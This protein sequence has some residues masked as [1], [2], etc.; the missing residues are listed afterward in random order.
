M[1]KFLRGP[2]S[3]HAAV[4]RGCYL[5]CLQAP[6]LRL[7]SRNWVVE[8]PSPEIAVRVNQPLT[9]ALSRGTVLTASAAHQ[10]DM[11]AKEPLLEDG[12]Q[13]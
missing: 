12:A 13:V 3:C 9:I 11:I 10:V 4:A 6:F 1:S 5:S 7:A 2:T 8:F